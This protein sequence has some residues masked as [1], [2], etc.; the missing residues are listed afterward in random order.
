MIIVVVGPTAVGKTKM[1][2]EL[3]KI[4]NGEIIN[5]DST[6]VYRGMDI[7]TAKV[8]KEE[9]QGIKHHLLDI[10]DVEDL[11]T[12]YDYQKD[13]REKIEEIKNKGKIPILVGGTGLYIKAAL[14]NYDFVDT[15][16]LDYIDDLS[17]EEIIKKIKEYGDMEIDFSNRRRLVST[18]KMLASEDTQVL[19]KNH[20]LYDDVIFI[21]LTTKRDILYEKIN[22]RFDAMLVNLVDEVKEF[23]KKGIRT[24]ALNTAIG[25]KELYKFF[26]DEDT[27]ANVID[28]CKQ[29]TRNYA[30]RQ[31]TWFN[32][33]MEIKWFD[34]NFEDFSKTL[35]EACLYIDSQNT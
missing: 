2:V 27:F 4:Y 31:Y 9:M 32:N 12:V 13:A 1:S 23:Y 6:Q 3:A 30:K 16:N 7:G 19:D 14:Y 24:K 18:L 17:D 8:T 11:Y 33:Q 5:A 15:D 29:T 34:V 28:E 21:G 22:K 25:Y 10:C 20:L 35:D 26:D